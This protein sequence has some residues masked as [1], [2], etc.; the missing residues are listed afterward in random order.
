MCR[1]C[2]SRK[3]TLWPFPRG[4]EGGGTHAVHDSS[5]HQKFILDVTRQLYRVFSGGNAIV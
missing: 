3:E 1:V 4:W 2:R 5:H